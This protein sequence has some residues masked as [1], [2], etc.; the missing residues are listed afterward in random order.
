MNIHYDI[1]TGLLYVDGVAF[2]Q[3]MVDRLRAMISQTTDQFEYQVKVF[4]RVNHSSVQ[5]GSLTLEAI[6]FIM[7]HHPEGIAHDADFEG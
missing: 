5:V 1:H 2:T 7:Q 3:E 4:D 6:D